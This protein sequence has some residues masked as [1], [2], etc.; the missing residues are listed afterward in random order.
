MILKQ[1]SLYTLKGESFCYQIKVD[2]H[3]KL[4]HT[5]A[6]SLIDGDASSLFSLKDRGFSGSDYEEGLERTY[7]YDYLPMEIGEVNRG[8]FRTPGIIIRDE[9]MIT[10]SDFRFSSDRIYS[11]IPSISPLPNLYGE[12]ETLELT[13]KD[14]C[15]GN[16]LI[17]SYSLISDAILTSRRLIA[18]EDIEVCKLASLSFDITYG[19]YDLITFAGRHCFERIPERTKITHQDISI[20]SR[21]G[22]SSH[23]V[24]PFAII[25]GTDTDETHGSCFGMHLLWSSS[26][27][28]D[29]GK[30]QYGA[31]RIN[32][33]MLDES[34]GYKLKAGEEL[35]LPAALLTY[36]D[37]GLSGL[38]LKCSDIIRAHAVR[39]AELEVENPV[40]LNSWE[41]CYFNF[42][43]EDLI[44]LAEEASSIGADLFVLDDGWFGSRNDDL[45]S[46]GDWNTNE[47]KLGM[48]L[49]EL[50]MKIKS[51][52]ML[53]GLWVEPEMINE[54]SDLYRKHPDW[55][56]TIPGRKPM[57]S[58]Y[59][60]VLD[61]SREDVTDYLL[62]TLTQILTDTPIDYIKWDMNRSLSDIASATTD[63]DKIIY[64]YEINLYRILESLR[65]RF[66]SVLIEGCAGGGGR[67]DLGMLCYTPQIWLSDNTDAIDRIQIQAGSSY[68]YP[69]SSF[70]SHLS[71]C[72][73]HQDGRIT[74]LVTRSS[75]AM[76]GTY[77]FELN[78]RVFTN[79]E[80][81]LLREEVR[82][83]K[84]NADILKNGDFYRIRLDNDIAVF[85]SVSKD[86]CKAVLIA[87][88]LSIHGND[89]DKYVK[90][91]GLDSSKLY[92]LS[93]G[94]AASGSFLMNAGLLITFKPGEY[95]SQRI[96]LIAEK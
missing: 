19:D 62:N 64:K 65:M 29:V 31:T 46:L 56:L 45:S 13:L 34:M 79:E 48:S 76:L 92:K 3:G 74:P 33:S 4:L 57:R 88:N 26:F 96:T 78:P 30:S 73:N 35:Q 83:Y 32:F 7:S 87:V 24:N 75:I 39:K 37:E 22:A 1:G 41:A 70:G 94:K 44:A 91:R 71:V 47:S 60:L 42:S 84:E 49:T 59:Q 5:Y 14:E 16:I 17:L 86:R 55:A 15:S 25:C 66:P 68:G 81:Q 2:K 82:F 8:D 85:L 90:L 27:R 43:G 12:A 21:R 61:L 38:S 67:F 6:G 93:G 28:L 11:G 95:S 20:T 72:P 52:G 36:S 89:V 50:A 58:R 63:A 54:D 40:L 10:A 23:Q 9:K 77:G 80:K 53:F 51:K 69:I 18:G